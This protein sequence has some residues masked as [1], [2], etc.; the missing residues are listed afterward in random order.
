MTVTLSWPARLPLPTMQGYGIDDDL[1]VE[2]SDM[3][4]GAARERVTSTAITSS[5][6]VQWEFTLT[7]YSIFEAWLVHRARGQWFN[8]TYLGGI[9]LVS[10]EARIQKGKAP[11]KFRNGARVTVTATLDVRDRPMLT[12]AELGELLAADEEGFAALFADIAAVHQVIN[13][14]LPGAP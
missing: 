4:S 12:D 5:I 1:K 9:G 14:D 6:Q 8:M 11:A 13:Y 2:R 3:E 7:E 10:A